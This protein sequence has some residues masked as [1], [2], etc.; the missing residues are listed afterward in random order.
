MKNIQVDCVL[1]VKSSLG[2]GPIWSTIDQKLYWVDIT[3]GLFCNFNPQ[4]GLNETLDLGRPIGCFALKRDGNAILALTDGFLN[5]T[6]KPKN[7][8]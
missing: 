2:E 7:L 3:E 6:K 1:N 4:N 5:L 8:L